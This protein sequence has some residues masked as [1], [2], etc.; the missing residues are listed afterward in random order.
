LTGE[1]QAFVANRKGWV[2]G[3]DWC[4]RAFCDEE[5]VVGDVVVDAVGDVHVAGRR[6]SDEDIVFAG[7]VES[8]CD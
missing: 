7:L 8:V 3:H 1:T 2:D 6:V 4:R 5:V